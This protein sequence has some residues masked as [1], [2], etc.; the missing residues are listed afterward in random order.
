MTPTVPAPLRVYIAGPYS[1]E[2]HIDVS[3]NVQVARAAAAEIWAKGHEAHCP[4]AATHYVNNDARD[5]LGVHIP[6]E[7]WLAHDLGILEAWAT[8]L[9]VIAESPGVLHEIAAAKAKPIPIYRTLDEVPE[10]RA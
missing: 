10:V 1:A 4:H 2:C 8:A 3:I 6:Y 5:L 7:R 9:F